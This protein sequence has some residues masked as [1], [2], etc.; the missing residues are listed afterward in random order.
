MAT[1]SLKLALFGALALGSVGL[2]APASAAPM[3][4]PGVA[5]ASDLAG[6]TPETVR[7]VCGPYRCFFRPGPRF[8]GGYGPRFY[9]GGPRFYG[10]GPRF[11]GRG[12]DYG[13]RRFY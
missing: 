9:G 6:V 7:W 12:Y 1:S 2:A 4:D 11:Y 3:I 5:H 10:G 13:P 8:Y